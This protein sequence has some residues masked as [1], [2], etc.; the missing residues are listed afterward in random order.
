MFE[1]FPR[2][3]PPDFASLNSIVVDCTEMFEVQEEMTPPPEPAMFRVK[4]E[5]VTKRVEFH[6]IR[7]APPLSLAMLSLNKHCL[8]VAT[9]EYAP[10]AAAPM[11]PRLPEQR[12]EACVV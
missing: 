1:L 8:I 11:E 6:S 12:S 4:L 5:D 7:R 9:Q 3:D 2:I 10:Y